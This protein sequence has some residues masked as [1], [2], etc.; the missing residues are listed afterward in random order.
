MRNIYIYLAVIALL[1]IGLFVLSFLYIDKQGHQSFLYAIYRDSELVGYEKMDRYVVKNKSIYKSSMEL[2]RDMFLEKITRKIMFDESGK[3]F[4]DYTKE[5]S[6][7]GAK[8]AI[9]IKNDNN[10]A[11]FL[12]IA[13]ATFAYLDKIITVGNFTMFEDEAIVTYPALVRRYNFKKRGEQFFNILTPVS[14]NFPPLT[15]II[16][17]TAIGKDVINIAGK[18]VRCENLVFELSNGNL[19]SVWVAQAFHNILMVN[20]PRTSFK[21]VLCVKKDIIPVEEYTKKSGLYSDEQ[22]VFKNEDISLSGVLSIPNNGEKPYPAVML[23]WNSGPLDRNAIGIFTDIAHT[24][25]ENGYCVFR[26]DKRGV[27]KS[28]GF[29]S[30]YDQSEEIADLRKAVEFLKSAPEVDPA[31]IAV[32]GYGEG[33]FYAAYLS[34]VEEK[35]IKC[36]IIMSAASAADPAKDDF[37]RMKEFIRRNITSNPQYLEN[38]IGTINQ[39][40]EIIKGKGDWIKIL[41]NSVF[42]KKMRIESDYDMTETL[43]KL[44]IPILILHGRKDNINLPEEAKELEEMLSGNGS[45]NFTVIYFADLDHFMGKAVRNGKVRD[46]IEIDPSVAKNI[47]S[48][49]A[50]NLPSPEKKAES[51]QETAVSPSAASNP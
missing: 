50:D 33:G 18:K 39:N 51:G 21:V 48:W 37:K 49:L 5:A 20:V 47:L 30:T 45:G 42:T 2:P 46:H 31:R 36:C 8:S 23:I 13:D 3:K 16:S 1:A 34:G 4:I 9:Y 43:K 27:G 7:N 17:I 14:P 35:S 29:F 12:G 28:Q 32:L 44:K 41:D 22:A 15:G 11:S 25:A 24:L 26:F 38:A 19:I 40:R 10:V 6:V